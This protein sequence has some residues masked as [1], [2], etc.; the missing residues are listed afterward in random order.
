MT[1]WRFET[2]PPGLAHRRDAARTPSFLLAFCVAMIGIAI[3]ASLIELA[4][5]RPLYARGHLDQVLATFGVSIA[6]NEAVI[7]IWGRE[8]MF[9]AP[10]SCGAR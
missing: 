1:Q 3:L 7:M 8:A 9:I 2:T 5:I 6:L 10:P 4:I